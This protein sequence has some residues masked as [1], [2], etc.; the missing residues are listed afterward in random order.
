ML[1]SSSNRLA[2]SET[3]TKKIAIGLSLIQITIISFISPS[4]AQSKSPSKQQI[5]NMFSPDIRKTLGACSEQGKV[6]LAAGAAANGSVRCG[7]G[8]NSAVKF[9]EYVNTLSDFITAGLLV[10]HRAVLKANPEVPL[11]TATAVWQQPTGKALLRQL[12]EQNLSQ[13]QVVSSPQSIS[14]LVDNVVQRSLPILQDPA[15]LENLFGTP[16]QYK[17]AVNNFCNPPGNSVAQ[18]QTLVPGLSSI[19]LYAICLQESGVAAQQLP[20]AKK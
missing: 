11:E 18:A 14:L 10:D 19:Q 20:K 1:A 6:N 3:Y 16:S 8:S 2:M 12:L 9:T 5:N 7:D 4:Q 17:L 13:T 15:S